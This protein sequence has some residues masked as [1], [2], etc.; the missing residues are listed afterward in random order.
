MNRLDLC[1]SRD[2]YSVQYGCSAQAT[3]VTGGFNR[4]YKKTNTK[5]HIVS[6]SLLLDEV[7]FKYFHAFYLDWQNYPQEFICKL[8]LEG[9]DFY[10]ELLQDYV[11]SFVKDS[12]SFQLEAMHFR[13]YFQ[14]DVFINPISILTSKPYTYYFR[15]DIDANFSLDDIELKTPIS[16][17]EEI[18][19]NFSLDDI[20]YR[21]LLNS[22]NI[23]ELVQANFSLDDI[24][25]T[26]KISYLKYTP[27]PEPIQANFSLTDIQITQFI[28]YINYTPSPEPIQAE[29]SLDDIQ[30]TN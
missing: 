19:A 26:A 8:I 15:E 14:L 21:E 28:R 10:G 3:Q 25:I 20:Q 17:H 24:Q 7:D 27:S 5:H 22:F 13:V 1:I 18:L 29:F 6:C 12:V 4:Y 30:I 16:N 9:Y 23:S 2:D 11:C